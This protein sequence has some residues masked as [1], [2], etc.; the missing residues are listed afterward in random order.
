M[1]LL[2]IEHIYKQYDEDNH[3][4]ID[5]SLKIKKGSIWSLVGESGSGKSTLLRIIAGLEV[6]DRGEVYFNGKTV[7]NP[8]QKLVPGY[9]EIQLIHQDHHLFP[10]PT[11]PENIVGPYCF[12]IKLIKKKRLKY[13]FKFWV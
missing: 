4:L 2:S 6:Q 10:I 13:L 11:V 5:F 1:T 12:S 7:L 8:A 9:E 3:A